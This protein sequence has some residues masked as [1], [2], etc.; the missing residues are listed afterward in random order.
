MLR[1]FARVD[2]HDVSGTAIFRTMEALRG[3]AAL[4]FGVDE[5][6]PAALDGVSTPFQATY[7]HCVLIGHKS[8]RP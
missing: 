3:F 5:A 4:Q 1:Q 6:S 2:G 7:C 8:S